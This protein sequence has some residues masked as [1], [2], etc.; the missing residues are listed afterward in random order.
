MPFV[1]N[2]DKEN[3][4]T[5]FMCETMYLNLNRHLDCNPRLNDCTNDELN[6]R[7]TKRNKCWNEPMK[8]ATYMYSNIISNHVIILLRLTISSSYLRPFSSA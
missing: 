5:P 1:L 7:I 2:I 8:I 3:L 6:D 4:C